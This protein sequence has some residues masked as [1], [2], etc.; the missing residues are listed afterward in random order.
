M[1]VIVVASSKGG[2]GKSTLS[3]NLAAHYALQGKRTA[4][5]DA[6]R[7]KSA[8]HWCEKRAARQRGAGAGAAV[9]Y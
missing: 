4:L 9:H 7:Q 3:T 8:T 5:I 6:D 2:A 1:H